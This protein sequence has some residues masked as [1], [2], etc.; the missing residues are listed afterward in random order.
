MKLNDIMIGEFFTTT[1][2]PK[3]VIQITSMRGYEVFG[4]LSDG[5]IAGPFLAEEL[6]PIPIDETF[7]EKNFEK[8][9][10]Y[11]IY[12]DYFDF[13]LHEINDGMYI[14]CYHCCEMPLPDEQ[15]CV[16]HV[17]QLQRFVNHCGIEKKLNL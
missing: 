11:G 13:S 7:L 6:V 8:K 9:V 2:W 4:R 12:D 16:C 5:I 3:K 15:I 10:L 14:V 1:K 17:H